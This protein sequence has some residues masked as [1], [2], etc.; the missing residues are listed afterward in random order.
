M[1]SLCFEATDG[2]P[3]PGMYRASWQKDWTVQVQR[4]AEK[5]KGLQPTYS[6]PDNHIGYS[7]ESE[8]VAPF[9]IEPNVVYLRENMSANYSKL[10]YNKLSYVPVPGSMIPPFFDTV[11][12]VY[13]DDS[14]PDYPHMGQLNAMVVKRF[15]LADRGK[16]VVMC[17]IAFRLVLVDGEVDD[18]V[19]YLLQ[20]KDFERYVPIEQFHDDR[21]GVDGGKNA[22]KLTLPY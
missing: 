1:T 21:C 5:C 8:T 16:Q 20:Q 6:A 19:E 11:I 2:R 9:C 22:I 12:R 15:P 14:C 13:H 3:Q 10:K 18:F 7:L 17:D 4:G